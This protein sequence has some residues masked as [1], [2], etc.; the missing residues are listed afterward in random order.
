MSSNKRRS[1]ASLAEKSTSQPPAPV[2]A[3]TPAP[4]ARP[5]ATMEKTQRPAPRRSVAPVR[6]DEF[7]R[8]EARLRADQ[9][10][11]LASLSK[12]LNRARKGS[13]ERITENTL[14]RIAVDLL[15]TQEDQ[16]N[17]TTEVELRN[18]VSL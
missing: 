6:Y 11:A 3:V 16:V 13:G 10:E 17:G 1:L 14:I 5:A 12:R 18:S 4:S 8:K 9:L 15:L 7:E 2:S